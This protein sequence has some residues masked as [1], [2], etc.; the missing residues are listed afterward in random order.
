MIIFDVDNSSSTHTDNREKYIL[1]PGE[2]PTQE[3]D[4]T[5]ITAEFKFIINFTASKNNFCLSL[6]YN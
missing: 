3:L 6:H 2:G 5:S 4:N 1:V